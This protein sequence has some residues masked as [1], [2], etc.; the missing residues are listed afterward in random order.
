MLNTLKSRIFL[1]LVVGIHTAT[2]V[3]AQPQTVD[4]DSA[5]TAYAEFK[6]ERVANI[7]ESVEKINGRAA[8]IICELFVRKLLPPDDERGSAACDYAVS[9]KDA[10][11]LVWRGIAGR[12]GL[13]SLGMQVTEAAALGYFAQA[14]ELD[15][16]PAFGRLC[17]HY[18][19]KKLFQQASAY[20]KYAGSR[21]IADGLYYHALMTI[22]GNGAVQNFK[23]G[24]EL[25]LLGAS[26]R[27][28]PSL[29]KLAEYCRDGSAGFGKNPVKAYSWILV[30]SSVDPDSNLIA[31][32]KQSL[33]QGLSDSQISYSQ[34]NA[35]NWK[36]TSGPTSKDFYPS[37]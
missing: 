19:K 33:A 8:G 24:M 27:S 31:T 32:A 22:E 30:A 1:F 13:P 3:S 14:A 16:P 10:H 5:T 28:A 26:L 17:E 2:A 9:M 34:K 4:F 36:M 37:K 18:Y 12:E 15:Y 11:G 29:L 6:Y 23:K 35:A 21:G 7:L 25:L 20:C